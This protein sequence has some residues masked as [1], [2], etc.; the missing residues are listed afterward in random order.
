MNIAV[1]YHSGFGHKK[2]AAEHIATGALKETEN[3]SCISILEAQGNFELLHQADAIVMGSP[4]WFGN[5]SAEFRRFMETT[6]KFLYRQAWK[7]KLAAGF[8]HTTAECSDK[9][10]ALIS[11]SLFA[12]HHGM[13]WIP[14]GALIDSLPGTSLSATGM[15][16]SSIG[17]A[18]VCDN[19]SKLMIPTGMEKAELFGH[20]IALITKQFSVKKNRANANEYF[21]RS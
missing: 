13:I 18:T 17:F 16:V 2:I 6:Q 10:N 14:T 15:T 21:K 19:E 5:V 8:I 12:A 7:N 1:V 4:T 3:V 11:I 20:H 9:L